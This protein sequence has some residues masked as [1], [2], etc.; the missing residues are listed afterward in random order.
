[1]LYPLSYGRKICW[2][3]QCNVSLSPL[4]A[5]P[6]LRGGCS[7]G[8]SFATGLPRAVSN[9]RIDSCRPASVACR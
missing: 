8:A 6:W 1:V 7:V 2:N 4:F 3:A 9:R 5:C